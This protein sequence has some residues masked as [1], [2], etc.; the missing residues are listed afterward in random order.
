MPAIDLRL[1]LLLFS[2]ALLMPTA[3]SANTDINAETIHPQPAEPGETVKMFITVENNGETDYSFDPVTIRTADGITSLGSTSV[4]GEPFTLCEDCRQV[5]TFT[6]QV[7]TDARSGSYPVRVQLTRGDAGISQTVEIEVDGS[8]NMLLTT[9]PI[10]ITPGETASFSMNVSN[11]GTEKASDVTIDP[12]TTEATVLPSALDIGPIQP[13]ETAERTARIRA[14]DNMAT[15]T[16]S[17]PVTLSYR[18]DGQERTKQTDIPFNVQKSSRVVMGDVDMGDA[19]IGSSS[20]LTVE[21]ENLGPGDAEQIRSELLCENATTSRAKSFVGQLGDD[22]SVPMTFDLTPEQ[23]QF[24]CTLQTSYSDTSDRSF[25]ETFPL[26]AE[27]DR[28]RLPYIIGGVI[29]IL[30]L[31]YAWMKRRQDEIAEI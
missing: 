31:G 24:D 22:E 26:T 14:D 2:L 10:D 18:E 16:H 23:R 6:L 17:I 7:D 21:L 5:G 12:E 27:E 3:A 15:G 4:L 29:A 13:G 11:T 25:S 30:I 9:A 28:S 1:V 19:V 20:T 8:A